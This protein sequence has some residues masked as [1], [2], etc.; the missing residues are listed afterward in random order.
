MDQVIVHATEEFLRDQAAKATFR[1]SQLEEHIQNITQR[2]YNTAAQL[3][4][5]IDG[6]HSWT[7]NALEEREISES[8]A[9]E[10]AEICGFELTREIEVEVNVTYNLTLMVPSNM[11]AEEIVSDIDFDAITYDTDMITNVY[12]SVD[13]VNF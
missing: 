3:Q 13:S 1:V 12:S 7:L 11:D 6:M 5:V 8:N 9:Q 4:S 10:I 2:D